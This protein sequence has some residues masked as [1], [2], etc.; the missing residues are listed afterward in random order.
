MTLEGHPEDDRKTSQG[1]VSLQQ[2]RLGELK[3]E[4]EII[5]IFY[6]FLT[7]TLTYPNIANGI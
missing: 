2:G 7:F 6:I 1:P 4:L 5:Y 3:H